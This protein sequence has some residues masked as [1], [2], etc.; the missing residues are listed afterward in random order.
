MRGCILQYGK[1]RHS[2]SISIIILFIAFL[3]PSLLSSQEY[4]S[5]SSTAVE[6][7][8]EQ[9][10]RES[11]EELDYQT[12]FYDVSRYLEDPLDIN[13]ASREELERLHL[14]TY[15]QIASLQQYI[16]DEGPLLTIYEL[17]LVY[18]FDE[19]LARMIEPLVSFET[20][21]MSRELAGEKQKPSHQLFLRFS[22]VLE[23]QKGYSPASDS[24]LQASP[25]ARYE[26]NRL[27]VLTKY[28]FRYGQKVEAGYTG[29]KD[30]GEPFMNRE[31][32]YGF[33][34]NSAYLRVNGVG[35]FSTLIAGAYQVRAGQGVV[36]GSGLSF[37][38]S[39]DII[40]IRKK[41]STLIPYTY[42]G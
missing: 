7:L 3:T 35:K 20:T 37:G 31:N 14:L 21:A 13:A 24:L 10:A 6:D 4:Q 36:L 26:G 8:I 34:F 18:G 22:S 30:A 1:F 23:E 15:F 39:P 12:L 28:R 25:N 33:D 40:N 2:L 9:I 19:G 41:G 16:R 38:K 17:P 32:K 27:K 5:T 29:E 11:E 42:T